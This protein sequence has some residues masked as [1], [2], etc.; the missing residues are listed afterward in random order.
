MSQRQ[1]GDKCYVFVYIYVDI[2]QK[3]ISATHSI[4]AHQRT[5]IDISSLRPNTHHHDKISGE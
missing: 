5:D 1:P 2:K 3:T 4:S